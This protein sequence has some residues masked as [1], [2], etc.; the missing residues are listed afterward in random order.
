MEQNIDIRSVLIN[1]LLEYGVNIIDEKDLQIDKPHFAEGG[2]G[3]VYKGKYQGT[4]D[5]AIK[6]LKEFKIDKKPTRFLINMLKNLV[7]EIHIVTMVN[8]P[9]FPIFYG[10]CITKSVYFVFEYINGETLNKCAN[11]LDFKAK[12]EVIK[13][14]TSILVDLHSRKIIHRDIKPANIMIEANNRTRLI[15][16]GISR[17]FQNTI[18]FTSNENYTIN[19]TAPEV[20]DPMESNTTK[21]SNGKLIVI[22]P[23]IDVWSIGCIISQIFS[24]IIPWRNICRTDLPI[25]KKLL[26]KK[27]FPI[28]DNITDEKVK[29]LIRKACTI[30]VK[31]R[32]TSKEFLDVINSVFFSEN[33]EMQ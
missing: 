16:F 30:D 20:V 5:V 19:Y 17:I 3:K 14:L 6:K 1:K 25:I 23:K 18:T 24:E 7:N 27:D 8:N 11:D 13:Q 10:V 28:P 21:D 26:E 31:Q 9:S 2:F 15:D 4:S 33:A 12:I 29:H 22:S 32:P